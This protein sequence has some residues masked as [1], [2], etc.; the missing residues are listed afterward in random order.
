MRTDRLR[1][2]ILTSLLGPDQQL[3]TLILS[4]CRSGKTFTLTGS[5][6]EPG[7]IPRAIEVRLLAVER[8]LVSS[9]ASDSRT[10]PLQDVFAFI[11]RH[12]G[13]EFL[14]RASYLEIYNEVIKDLLAPATRSVEIRGAGGND[15]TLHP[16]REEVVT[17]P[18]H[19]REILARGEVNRRTAATDWNERSSRSHSVFRCVASSRLDS[20]LETDACRPSLAPG[21]AGSSSRAETRS[22]AARPQPGARTRARS[23]ARP[24]A[25]AR[26]RRPGRAPSCVLRSPAGPRLPP[27]ETLDADLDPCR[28]EPHRPGRLREG[29]V[30]QAAVGRGQ[31]HQ[32]ESARAQAGRLDHRQERAQEG[33]VRLDHRCSDPNAHS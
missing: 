1:A 31:V 27:R 25:S 3:M 23:A 24:T 17:N 6:S 15:V 14:L 18:A 28:A 8:V 26:A 13:K 21:R 16:V 11:R 30:G 33:E 9:L 20:R 29:D 32:H 4:A 12:S 5:E 7:I 22:S 19:V 2:Y 10:H